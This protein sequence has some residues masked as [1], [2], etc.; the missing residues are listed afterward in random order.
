MNVCVYHCKEFSV[1]LPRSK[2]QGRATV[3]PGIDTLIADILVLSVAFGIV[4][5]NYFSSMY[6]NHAHFVNRGSDEQKVL[7]CRGIWR[8]I[9]VAIFDP[10]VNNDR[11]S[12]CGTF[13]YRLPSAACVCCGRRRMLVDHTESSAVAEKTR[14]ATCRLKLLQSQFN[15]TVDNEYKW[16]SSATVTI[17]SYKRIV[18]AILDQQHLDVTKMIYIIKRT[19]WCN[20]WRNV[21]IFEGPTAHYDIM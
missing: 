2:L 14:D 17:K 7:L 12:L 20:I 4:D 10:K 6:N 16:A 1:I 3:R 5:C 15:T 11:R 21:L 8:E 19:V 13:N 18:T 9:Y